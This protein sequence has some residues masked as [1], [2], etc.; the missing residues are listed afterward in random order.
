MRFMDEPVPV[1]MERI[2]QDGFR[3]RRDT[4]VI[5]NIQAPEER[6]D[7]AQVDLTFFGRSLIH[8]NITTRPRSTREVIG[9][10]RAAGLVVCDCVWV[11]GVRTIWVP[12]CEAHGG[13]CSR[14]GCDHRHV[15]EDGI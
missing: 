5:G 1:T 2:R 3:S 14:V 15:S 13:S 8:R 6:I 10:A 7:L 4:V 9:D 11:Q 12:W